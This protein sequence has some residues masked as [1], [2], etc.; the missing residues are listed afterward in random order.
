MKIHRFIGNFDLSKKE[1]QITNKEIV[2]QMRNVLR[3]KEAEL[4]E[5]CDGKNLSGL[6]SQRPFGGEFKFISVW[7]Y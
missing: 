4:V 2:N 6:Y 3:L 5:L 1:L 7:I